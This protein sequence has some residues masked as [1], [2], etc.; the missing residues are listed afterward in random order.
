MRGSNISKLALQIGVAVVINVIVLSPGLIGFSLGG[1]SAFQT[2]VAATVLVVSLCGVLYS[3]YSLLIAPQPRPK[4][5]IQ[6]LEQREDYAEALRRYW[7]VK[8]AREDVTAGLEQLERM[9]RKKATLKEALGQRFDP[10]E[11]SYQKFIGV[12][13]EVERLFYLNVRGLVGKLGAFDEQEYERSIAPG[14]SIRYSSKLQQEK[15]A[16]FQEYL[17]HIRGY[18]NAN[19]EIL[20]KLDRLLLELV[21][22][23]SADYAGLERMPG[24]LEIDALISQTAFYKS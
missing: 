4:P 5:E 14:A 16:L 15:V 20:L 8:A 18:T 6:R 19:E 13:H 3:G 11:L 2:A 22:L 10:H 7:T 9:E 21:K 17:T 1:E 23:D 12:I 24:M